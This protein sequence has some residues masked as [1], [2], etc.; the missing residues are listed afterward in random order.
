MSLGLLDFGLSCS[1]LFCFAV[2]CLLRI[3]LFVFVCLVLRQAVIC[4]TCRSVL[5]CV[6]LIPS[7]LLDAAVLLLCL[8]VP[9]VGH[10]ALFPDQLL[11][12]ALF[13]PMLLHFAKCL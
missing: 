1:K 6:C 12:L 11:F 5:L 10:A 8:N 3:A 4:C 7:I 13:S 2:C 9:Y